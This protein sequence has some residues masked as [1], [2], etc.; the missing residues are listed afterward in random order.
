MT[1]RN[2]GIFTADRDFAKKTIDNLI[3]TNENE[4][5]HYDKNQLCCR[6]KNGERYIW[7]DPRY[8]ARGYRIQCATVDISTCTISYLQSIFQSMYFG[9]KEEIKVVMSRGMHNKL[10]ELMDYLEKI[11]VL[12]G[13]IDVNVYDDINGKDKNIS[14]RVYMDSMNIF[15]VTNR[16][17]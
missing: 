14:L 8:S 2:Y 4:I 11:V 17:G 1:F 13:N 7:I 10:F 15:G 12:K 16:K 5:E 9:T 3:L 6:M